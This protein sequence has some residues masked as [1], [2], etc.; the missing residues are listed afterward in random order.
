M[1]IS[2]VGIGERNNSM[3]KLNV[4]KNI[5]ESIIHRRLNAICSK[6]T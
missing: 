2:G 4:L 5:D 6:G 3:P 1:L